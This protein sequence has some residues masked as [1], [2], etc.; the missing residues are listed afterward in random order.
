MGFVIATTTN[1]ALHEHT[2]EGQPDQSTN[3]CPDVAGER[4]QHHAQVQQGVARAGGAL[5]LG[6]TNNNGITGMY[7]TDQSSGLFTN[8]FTVEPRRYGIAG[9]FKF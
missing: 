6:G 7:V 2:N 3:S 8:I 4:L 5:L 1:N 9:G